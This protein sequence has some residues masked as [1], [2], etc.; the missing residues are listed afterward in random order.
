[1]FN[2]F[3]SF[4]SQPLLQ[5]KNFVKKIYWKKSM[6]INCKPKMTRLCINLVTI[7]YGGLLSNY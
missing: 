1:M 2:S 4:I 3:T 6:G 7:N 5:N